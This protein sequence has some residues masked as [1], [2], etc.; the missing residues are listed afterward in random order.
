MIK[1][2]VLEEIETSD[3]ELNIQLFH[4]VYKYFDIPGSNEGAEDSEFYRHELS[5]AFV[6]ARKDDAYR[7][8]D[9]DGITIVYYEHLAIR[10]LPIFIRKQSR[11]SV[12]ETVDVAIK[13]Y[14]RKKIINAT[15]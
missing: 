8:I 11:E 9:V 5:R 3:F 1:L 13:N 15:K 14:I 7:Q 6:R 10:A 12:L 4:K 2:A